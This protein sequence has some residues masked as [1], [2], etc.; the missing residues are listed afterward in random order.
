MGTRRYISNSAIYHYWGKSIVFKFNESNPVK[1]DS[2][3]T[4]ERRWCLKTNF[5]L[6]PLC[7]HWYHCHCWY[8]TLFRTFEVIIERKIIADLCLDHS[9]S[10]PVW[11]TPSH[12]CISLAVFFTVFSPPHDLYLLGYCKSSPSR[13]LVSWG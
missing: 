13:I 4:V 6:Y 1:T 10:I 9:S 7:F 8:V 3:G 12:N 11:L 5:T 2:S